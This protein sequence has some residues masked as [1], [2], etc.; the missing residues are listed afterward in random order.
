M[1]NLTSSM[2]LLEEQPIF[3]INI[4]NYF[5]YLHV[6]FKKKELFLQEKKKG[7][8]VKMWP[9]KDGRLDFQNWVF[10]GPFN[11]ITQKNIDHLT[12]GSRD[13]FEPHQG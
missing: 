7:I 12:A 5:K 6:R 1:L 2:F 8:F 4:V 9:K 13:Q 3:G 11:Q 10:N